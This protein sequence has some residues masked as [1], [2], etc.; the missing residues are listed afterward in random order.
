MT[1]NLHYLIFNREL[2]S[3]MVSEKARADIMKALMTMRR[4]NQ[5]RGAFR[6][7]LSRAFREIKPPSYWE[8]GKF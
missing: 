3:S 5:R 2:L 7:R 1:E 4:L 6:I 8:V